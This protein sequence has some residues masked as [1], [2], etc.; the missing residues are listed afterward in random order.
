[1]GHINKKFLNLLAFFI[2]LGFL[3]V[4]ITG[5]C[6][7]ENNYEIYIEGEPTYELENTIKRG[8][9]V[10]GRSYIIHIPFHNSGNQR[11]DKITV[12]MS[13]EEGFDLYQEVYIG[14]GE[15]KDV[16][17]N[18]S[19]LLLRN[20]IIKVNYYPSDT[21]TTSKYNSGSTRFT[22]EM[23]SIDIPATSTPGFEII[24]IIF[25]MVICILLFNKKYKN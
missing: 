5:S 24:S 14:P 11:S 15:T 22:L 10:I 20:Q 16:T 21:A 1:M 4:I 25:A 7:A 3:S 23:E 13:D 2:L 17:F 18:W 12:N 9:E 6:Y 19:T 8:N